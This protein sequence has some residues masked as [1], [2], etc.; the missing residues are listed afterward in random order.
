MHVEKYTKTALGNMLKHYSREQKDPECR[1]NI[2]INLTQYN[3]NLAPQREVSDLQFIQQRLEEVKH[4]NRD[5]VNIIADWII[6]L[7][8]DFKGD[9]EK[10]FQTA[11]KGF[12]SRYEEQNVVSAWVHK[13][14]P[15]AMP[16]M[17]F[18]FMPIQRTVDKNNHDIEKL[19][20]KAILNRQELK[21][22]HPFMERYLERNHVHAHLLN[23]KTRDGN[24]SVKE[25]K[26]EQ[27][28]KDLKAVQ[29]LRAVQKD[30][31]EP[32][33]PT[34]TL[35]GK[36]VSFEQYQ[37]DINALNAKL[38]QKENKSKQLESDLNFQRYK[39][40]ELDK[41]FNQEHKEF[42]ELK[43]KQLDKEYLKQQM[44]EI[45]HLH[46]M[47]RFHNH[48]RDDITISGR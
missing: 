20:A 31:V 9:E 4:L 41:N 23:E 11:Y 39:Y 47:N 21:E 3:Y 19:N 45:E 15:Q 18:C 32:V 43:E 25:L 14:E 34:R 7:P 24:K 30:I 8:K 13:D 22:I 46:D 16:H 48:T 36:V 44:K 37:H 12:C 42:L 29:T 1:D 33:Q 2:N 28:I 38:L 5:D 17:H 26:E 10:F 40:Q 35:K 27:A 6:T